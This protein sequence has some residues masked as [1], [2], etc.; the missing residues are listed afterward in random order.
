MTIDDTDDVSL[1]RVDIEGNLPGL[2]CGRA[3]IE[4]SLLR[5]HSRNVIVRGRRGM[6]HWNMKMK[7]GQEKAFFVSF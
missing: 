7:T 6:I 5:Q 4:N 1:S 2:D 3:K